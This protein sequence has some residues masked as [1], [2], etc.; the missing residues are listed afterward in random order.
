[1]KKHFLILFVALSGMVLSIPA[2]WLPIDARLQ[3]A[4]WFGASDYATL[5]ESI[6]T[7][8]FSS[9]PACPEDLPGWRKAQVI[10]GTKIR[11]S[12]ACVP[13][14]PYTVATVVLGSNHVSPE[15]LKKS[16]LAPDAV[17]KGRDLDG[18]GDPDE[19]HIRLEV[20]ELNGGSPEMQE[21]TTQFSIAPGINPGLWVFAPRHWVWP[22]KTLSRKKPVLFCDYL[23]Q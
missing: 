11:A 8:P 2:D 5:P 20:I 16:G 19:I 15:T 7:A 17:V 14:N 6:T 12:Q 21:P 1:M 3:W 10:E 4:E 23:P 18:D 9:E 13:D 22:L